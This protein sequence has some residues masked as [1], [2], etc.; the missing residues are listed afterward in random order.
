M[1]VGDGR[2]STRSF[3]AAE[4]DKHIFL[5]TLGMI[6]QKILFCLLMTPHNRRA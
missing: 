2:I 5:K 4:T 1:C 3:I 6:Y